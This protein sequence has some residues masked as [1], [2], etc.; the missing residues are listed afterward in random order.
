[1]EGLSH[2]AREQRDR[3]VEALMNRF[4]M[5]CGPDFW[6][7]RGSEFQS[8]IEQFIGDEGQRVLR[9]RFEQL[10]NPYGWSRRTRFGQEVADFEKR[11]RR[12][13]GAD[14]ALT[15]QRAGGSD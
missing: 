8:I 5:V 6:G 14:E 7:K 2:A 4:E 13:L 10:S 11:L 12:A 9:E 3:A 1:M 15:P